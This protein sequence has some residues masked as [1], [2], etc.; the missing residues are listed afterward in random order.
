M[1]QKGAKIKA[2]FFD[3]DMTLV[4]SMPTAKASYK[5]LSEA[6]GIPMTKKGFKNYIGRRFSTSMDFFSKNK[7]ELRKKMTKIYVN[8]HIENFKNLTAYGLRAL[9]YLRKNKI[10]I[11]IISRNKKEILEKETKILKIPYD[12]ILS[13]SDMKHGEEKHQIML[14]ILKKLNLKRDEVYY[15]GDHI[16][17]IIEANK[18]KIKIVSVTTGVYSMKELKRLKPDYIISDL[19]KIIHIIK[20]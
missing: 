2:I 10:K 17:D 14:R 7:V 15:V 3:F 9:N 4:N 8:S 1:K 13:D 18:A 19:N 6:S 12:L 20:K 16:N 5:A 11:V